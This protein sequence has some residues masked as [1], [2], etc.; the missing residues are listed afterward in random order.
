MRCCPSRSR[1]TRKEVD[2]GRFS[3][4]AENIVNVKREVVL[5]AEEEKK[6]ERRGTYLV[7]LSR[8]NVMLVHVLATRRSP[9]LACVL[10][11]EA[12]FEDLRTPFVT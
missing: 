2:S 9:R 7:S 6:K 4:F 8:A 1:S 11:P 10:Y 5:S 3:S 12:L